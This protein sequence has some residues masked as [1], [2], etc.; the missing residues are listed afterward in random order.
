[1][2]ASGTS[3][4]LAYILEATHGTTPS[5]PEF[6]IQRCISRN[7][8]LKKAALESQ[9][10]SAG[11]QRR[12]VRHGFN[13]IEAEIQ[14]ELGLESYNDL[15][16]ASVGTTAWVV[17]T[18]VTNA[19]STLS[20]TATT[21][22]TRSTG[23]W[24]DDGYRPGDW[25]LASGFT[26]SANNGRWRVGPVSSVNLTIQGTL[27]NES[28]ASST[29]AF[30]GKK[31]VVAQANQALQ[32]FSI[33]REILDLDA[34]GLDVWQIFR[35]CAV[36]QLSVSAN[37]ESLVTTTFRLLGMSGTI[38]AA[39]TADT[40]GGNPA[41]YTSA[42]TNSPFAAIDSEVY[43]GAG[44][45]TTGTQFDFTLD[46][47]RSLLPVLGSAISTDV[48]EGVAKVSGTIGMLLQSRTRLSFFQNESVEVQGVQIKFNELGTT[49][50]IVFNFYKVKFTS[51]DI[52]PPQ[53]GAVDQ[54]VNFEALEQTFTGAGGTIYKETMHIQRSTTT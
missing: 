44:S 30:I 37:P 28:G 20:V 32:T 7:V 1:M 41:T 27:I 26:N 52:D 25:I 35:G 49:D 36:N 5:T 54:I 31:A 45:L 2:V 10:V 18:T 42:P 11:R 38:N 46:N 43:T 12:D 8:N 24:I 50:F 39:A 47:Q 15:L 14:V 23:N 33:E 21:T 9:E 6:K 17:P 19:G 40:T 53:N 22:F 29:I 51:C 3:A 16:L 48:Y 13:S 4:R 34:A